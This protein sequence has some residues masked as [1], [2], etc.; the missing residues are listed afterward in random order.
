M[1]RSEIFIQNKCLEQ[2]LFKI[3]NILLALLGFGRTTAYYMHG[4]LPPTFLLPNSSLYQDNYQPQ[5]KYSS[6]FFLCGIHDKQN[7]KYKSFWNSWHISI[8]HDIHRF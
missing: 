5:K 7:Y 2:R 8:S 6:D 3:T 1:D 4:Y